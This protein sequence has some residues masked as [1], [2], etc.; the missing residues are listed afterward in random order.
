MSSTK[1]AMNALAERMP[2]AF[3]R[4]SVQGDRAL[5]LITSG[6]K[7]LTGYS[8]EEWLK[9]DISFKEL[10]DPECHSHYRVVVDSALVE[11]KPYSVEYKITHKNGAVLWVW[12]QGHGVTDAGSLSAIEGYI[13]DITSQKDH[14][15]GLRNALSAKQQ[16]LEEYK[17]VVDCSAIVSKTDP[18]G[19]ITYVNDHFCKVSG[20]SPEELIGSTHAIVRHP[21]TRP[22]IFKDLWS[23]ILS[24]NTWKGT[25]RNRAKNGQ[26]Y[27]VNSAISPIMDSDGNIIEFISVRFDVTSLIEKEKRIR[28]QITDQLTGLP[29]RQ[30]LLE[31][32]T[33]VES[34]SLAILN[35]NDFKLVNE[36]YGFA[37]GDQLLRDMA[38]LLSEVAEL[39]DLNLYRL[40]GDEFALFCKGHLRDIGFDTLCDS[41]VSRVAEKVITIIGIEFALA[42]TIGASNGCT[43]DLLLHADIALHSAK[44]QHLSVQI[45]DIYSPLKRQ[46]DNN[47]TWLKRIRE[48]IHEDRIEVFAQPILDVDSSEIN[49]YECLMRL[50]EGENYISPYLFLQAAKHGRLYGDLTRIVFSKACEFFA[51]RSDSF[52]INITAS[53][54]LNPNTSNYI[55]RTIKR[56]GVGDRLVFELVESEGIE[57]S[58]LIIQFFDQVKAMGCSLAIDD[59]GT[60]YSNFEYLLKLDI[61]YIKIDGSLIRYIDKDDNARI[62]AETVVDFAR[63]LNVKTVAE[64]VHNYEVEQCAREIGVDFLQGFLLGEPAPL[65]SL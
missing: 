1:I 32:L 18:N 65:D 33:S 41:I 52:S 8:V 9:G 58:E 13:T 40:S 26:D 61:D 45:Y 47:I 50:R 11:G 15:V 5:L 43:K 4:R 12:E 35:I 25:L 54:I 59:F 63:R 62:V 10:I 17:G 36:Y 57:D 30:S 60:G 34:G 39:H 42:V 3:Y 31:D 29:N 64:F 37:V 56:Y 28:R 21:Q 6:C 2:G 7:E 38:I 23:T 22:D 55:I 20:Y 27:Y 46:I 24:G 14:E 16:L 53:D 19:V 48:A 51:E 44:E 49:R